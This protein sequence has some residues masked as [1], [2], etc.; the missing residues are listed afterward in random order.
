MSWRRMAWNSLSMPASSRITSAAVAQSSRAKASSVRRSIARTTSAAWR[1][2]TA[3]GGGGVPRSWMLRAMRAI[4]CAS[5]PMRSRSVTVLMMA[6]IMRRSLAAGWRL[7]ITWLQS[8]SSSTSMAFTRWSL[9]ITSAIAARSPEP[10]ASTARRICDST[11]PPICSTRERMESRSRSYCFEACSL[12]PIVILSQPRLSE[13]AGDVVLGLFLLRLDEQVVGDAELDQLAN[14]HVGREIR[15]PRGL[16]HVV[17]HDEDRH[18]LLEVVDQ[19]LDRGG[20]DRVE[21]R[22][23]LVEQQQLRV[24]GASARRARAGRRRRCR[25]CSSGTDWASGTPCRCACALRSDPPRAPAGRY[26]P[27]AARFG[28]RS[29]CPDT[30]RA[31]G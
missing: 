23:R 7:T 11:S 1:T 29:G 26:Y 16:L 28:R 22:G 25:R 3:V 2:S 6:R 12:A 31:S 9:A 15:D 20:G 13:S 17:R 18:P 21:R 10:S 4:F 14:V 8:P 27:G 19:H 30:G 5:S 24:G